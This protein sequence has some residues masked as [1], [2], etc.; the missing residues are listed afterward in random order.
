MCKQKLRPGFPMP[1]GKQAIIFL[2]ILS[3]DKENIKRHKTAQNKFLNLPILLSWKVCY[4]GCTKLSPTFVE[5]FSL[6]AFM[7]IDWFPLKHVI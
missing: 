2:S 7:L 3:R 5:Q 4:D 1:L 6:S